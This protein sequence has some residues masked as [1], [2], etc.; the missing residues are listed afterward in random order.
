MAKR[1]KASALQRELLERMFT[2]GP[3]RHS[4]L[5]PQQRTAL[6]HPKMEPLVFEGDEKTHWSLTP[7]GN[8]FMG[9]DWEEIDDDD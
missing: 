4:E 3:I 8:Y 9:A 1:W 6:K 2:S 5:T 7:E